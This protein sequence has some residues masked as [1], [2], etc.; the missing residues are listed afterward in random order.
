M[1]SFWVVL[2]IML[3]VRPVVGKPG[4]PGSFQAR[5]AV[6]ADLLA[7]AAVFVV[8]GHISHAGV[9]PDGIPEHL[10]TIK[11]GPQ[12]GGFG[13]FQQVRVLGLEMAEER[14]DPRLVGR[15]AGSPE[16]HGNRV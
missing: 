9:Q 13:N 5:L 7:T 2:L 14:F 11:L 15:C 10:K 4:A 3:P 8:R 16:M 1:G 6:F 12:D